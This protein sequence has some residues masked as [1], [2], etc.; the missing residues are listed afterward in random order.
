MP[1]L[2]I[3]PPKEPK[4]FENGSGVAPAKGA[5]PAESP[6]LEAAKPKAKMPPEHRTPDCGTRDKASGGMVYKTGGMIRVSRILC[7]DSK[8]S[9][10]ESR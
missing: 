3:K 2:P 1:Q 6:T 4:A 8:P 7:R 9:E 5:K 10:P